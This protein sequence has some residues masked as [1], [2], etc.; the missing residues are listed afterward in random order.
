M[1]WARVTQP[2]TNATAKLIIARQYTDIWIRSCGLSATLPGLCSTR[3]VCNFLDRARPLR[4]DAAA[5]QACHSRHILTRTGANASNA[6]KPL[7]LTF[8]FGAARRV[9]RW[10]AFAALRPFAT[11][12]TECAP[13]FGRQR[14]RSAPFTAYFGDASSESFE[15]TEISEPRIWLGSCGLG[16]TQLSLC[17]ARAVR[18]FLERAHPPWLEAE[19]RQA[20]YSRVSPASNGPNHS[21]TWKAPSLTLGFRAAR[22]VFR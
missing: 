15:R 12:W 18:N 14:A 1:E 20:C 2:A 22:H 7:T 16:A 10:R 3:A 17:S 19:W 13:L 9:L 11:F 4:L 8:G 6:W 5:R 21:G